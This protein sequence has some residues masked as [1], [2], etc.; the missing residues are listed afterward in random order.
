MTKNWTLIIALLAL[1]SLS[2]AQDISYYKAI[3]KTSVPTQVAPAQFK[4]MEEN[5]LQNFSRPESYELLATSFGNTTEK[6][7][8][9]IYGEVYCNL[10]SDSDHI[11]Q[12][13]SLVYRWYEGSLSRQNNGLSADLTEN[14]QSSPKRVP[15]ESLF[16]QSFLIGAVSV[17][18]DFPPLSIQRL[19][20]IRKKDRKSVV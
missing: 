20:E 11:S 19:T 2:A 9:V 14:A 18:S 17:K 8:A 6:I 5:A 15:F 3:Q 7:W 1:N 10:S 16:E 12:I 13:G 4:E